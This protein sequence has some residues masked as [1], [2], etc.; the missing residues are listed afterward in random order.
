MKLAD[1][2]NAGKAVDQIAAIGKK[3]SMAYKIDSW[4][5]NEFA[6]CLA[7]INEYK[8]GMIIKLG[9]EKDGVT[10]IQE[11]A[12]EMAD[13]MADF[14]EYLEQDAEIPALDMTMEELMDAL[15]PEGFI[16][17]TSVLSKLTK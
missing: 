4:I 5:G 3:P 15:D 9:T 6:P 1:V 7:K 13:F 8:N 17:G 11:G 10:S 2:L 16:T 12:P 14:N